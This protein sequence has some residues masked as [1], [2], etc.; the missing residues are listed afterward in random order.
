MN[1]QE[2]GAVAALLLW[3]LNSLLFCLMYSFV[4]G[5]WAI[6]VI[7]FA[8]R[9]PVAYQVLSYSAAIVL[10]VIIAVLLF[11]IYRAF[12]LRDPNRSL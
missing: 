6:K 5:N 10:L 2:Q 12:P 3:A 9:A 11:V 7:C 8:A 4:M 1:R